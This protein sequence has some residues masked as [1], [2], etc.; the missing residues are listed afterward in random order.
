[1]R[2]LFV[3]RM[4][5]VGLPDASVQESRERMQ[6]AVKNASQPFPWQRLIVNP[7]PASVR[8]QA[9]PILT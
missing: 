3:P 8:E 4:T 5:I 9:R 7:T 2:W 6:M 1:M